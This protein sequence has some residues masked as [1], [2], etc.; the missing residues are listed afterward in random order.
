MLMYFVYW[1][2]FKGN[3]IVTFSKSQDLNIDSSRHVTMLKTCTTAI[4]KCMV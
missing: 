2:V 1:F 4:N 3:Q